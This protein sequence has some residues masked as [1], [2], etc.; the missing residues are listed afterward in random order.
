[1]TNLRF[2]AIAFARVPA[3]FPAAVVRDIAAAAGLATGVALVAVRVA[4]TFANSLNVDT[5]PATANKMGIRK[6]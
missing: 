5:E 4:H 3:Q 2:P 6:S 1:M